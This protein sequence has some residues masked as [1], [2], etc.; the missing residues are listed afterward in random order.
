MKIYKVGALFEDFESTWT[1]PI[2]VFN[3]KDLAYSIKAKWEKFFKES[4][5]LLEEPEN[6]DPDKDDWSEEGYDEYGGFS[7][8]DS[9]QYNLLISKYS[10][11]REFSSI[12]IEEMDLNVDCFID[13]FKHHND[14]VKLIIEFDRDFK[15]GSII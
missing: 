2:G 5:S 1:I 15:L 10:H 14:M 3:D 4:E 12:E 8:R 6:W 11:V 9:Y 13:G 7:W